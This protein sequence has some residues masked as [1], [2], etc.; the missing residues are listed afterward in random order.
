ISMYSATQLCQT[1]AIPRTVARQ[2]PLFMGSSRQEYWTG[3]SF[4]SP[5][6]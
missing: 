2:A 5:G 1:L 3:L 4:P 6:E